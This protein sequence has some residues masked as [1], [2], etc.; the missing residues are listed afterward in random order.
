M[1]SQ[2]P[3]PHRRSP[4]ATLW[5]L[6]CITAIA[7]VT[8]SA[9]GAKW[10]HGN[11]NDHLALL[12]FKAN[13]IDPLGV[14][15]SWNS[16]HHICEWFGVTC[17]R[18][19]RR[20]ARLE[21][22]SQGL[23][24][25]ISPH[26]GNLSFLRVLDLV[27]N[28]FHSR[29]P[30]EVGRLSRLQYFY[31]SNNSL[32]GSIP[33]SL[34]SCSNLVGIRLSNNKLEGQLPVDLGFLSKLKRLILGLNELNG[35]IPASIG[36]LTSLEHLVM[37]ENKL[38][39]KIPD[40]LGNLRN[41][42]VLSLWDNNLVGNIPSSV[43]NISSMEVLAVSHNRLAGTLPLDLGITLPNIQYF[44]IAINQFFGPIPRSISNM[45]QLSSFI[46]QS[47]NFTGDVPSFQQMSNLYWFSVAD[48]YLGSEQA[49]DLNFLCSLANSTTL[50]RLHISVNNFGGA[51]PKCIGNMSNTLND[52][53][54]H[55]NALSGTLPSSIGY[56]VGLE[57][58]SLSYNSF[59]GIIPPEIG[60]LNKIKRLYLAICEF[61]GEIPRTLGNLTVMTI[62]SLLGNNLTGTIPSSLGKCQSLL[63]L[64]LSENKLAGAIPPEIMSLSSL[65]IY[66]DF[67]ENDLAGEL[68]MEIGNLKSLTQLDLSRNRLLGEIPSS[69]GSCMSLMFLSMQDNMFTGPIP[70]TLSSLKGIQ[71]LNL[72]HN[73]LSGQIPEF[74]K[75][76]NLSI[77]DLSF[78]NFQGKLPKE[79]VFANSSATSVRGNKELCGGLPEYRLPKCQ[80]TGKSS[81][82][83][84]RN[85]SIYKVSG[86]LATTLVFLLLF[87]LW[88]RK[89][90]K[91]V[92]SGASN[93]GFLKV[94]YG[95]LLKATD[96]FSSA[97]L[98]GTGSFGSVFR[99]V[100]GLEQ[101]AIAV[102]VLNLDRHGASKSFIAECEALRNI[103]HRNLVKVLT[104]CSG[105]DYQG[106]DFKALVYEFM[107]NGSLDEWLH[108]PVGT[109]GEREDIQR[110][111]GL[112][113]RVNIASDVACALDY[114][115][116]QCE[117][118]IVHC[119]LKP[120]N[121]LI[122]GE[123]TGHV[124][125]FGLVRFMPEATREL[126][127]D[128][129]SSIGV[130]G[131][132]G[133]IAPE[134]GAGAEVSINGDVYSYG[135]LILEMFTGK[136]PTDNMFGDGLN[137]HSFAMAA[138]PEQ[139]LQIIDPVL[140]GESQNEDESRGIRRSRRSHE[141]LLKI[142]ECLV[143][144]VEIG[145][146]CSSEVPRDR[147]SIGD[148]AAALQAIQNKLLGS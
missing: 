145:V 69:L 19:H 57:V 43:T 1:E 125:D 58:L 48:N 72:S 41:L 30:L 143:S 142:Q 26:I 114:L 59:S 137:F 34:S 67:S 93:D 46:I 28:S 99:G 49:N 101:T 62:L 55:G 107:V 110:E 83:R 27:N 111:L 21:L 52:F 44:S 121:I 35:V 23:C 131:S 47:N 94:S 109:S 73:R 88:H 100:L 87:F 112:V 53:T 116:H 66:A 16:S 2:L 15:S 82:G 126:I 65:S 6:H 63:S 68:P 75:D 33:P 25:T 80:S 74:L 96:G 12:E 78:N 20:V 37:Q 77:L 123:M 89:Q 118:P 92:A 38:G 79:G 24:G 97:N 36:N 84:V 5:L 146:V 103:R 18:R 128:Q 134:Y 10:T 9:S 71:E 141:R 98:I 4:A 13:I 138:L 85:A 130:K 31:L 122:D 117:T 129:T 40:T 22:K 105:S 17:G 11:E 139:V 91:T 76:L 70:S 132:L 32:H 140:L 50:H 148:V 42:K 14:L 86:I 124:G 8:C 115:H 39:G 102:K 104:A 81:N 106:N 133:Y 135:I 144:I 113:Q 45:S 120:S 51:M 119:D 7:L 108:P 136:R 3:L 127:S 56:L 64:D 54:L 29:I 61:T 95:D 147:M 90:R 60:S